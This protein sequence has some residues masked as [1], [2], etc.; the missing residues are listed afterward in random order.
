MQNA[1]AKFDQLGRLRRFEGL[2]TVVHHGPEQRLHQ[3]MLAL[4]GL[5]RSNPLLAPHYALLPPSSFH[6]T[7]M[8]LLAYDEEYIRAHGYRGAEGLGHRP[9][10]NQSL[11]AC[12]TAVEE[13]WDL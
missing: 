7:C 10:I 13:C 8:D 9:S 4:Q 6:I 5:I 2:T 3:V 12:R 1:G 11:A